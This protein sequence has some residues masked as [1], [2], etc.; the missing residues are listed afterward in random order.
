MKIQYSFDT[1]IP[2]NP[3]RASN[4]DVE[5]GGQAII[6]TLSDK[7]DPNLFIRFQSW[8]ET[9]EHTSMKHF[10]GKRVRVTIECLDPPTQED[11]ELLKKS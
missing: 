2:K 5:D 1:K 8:D 9:K 6:V 3:A 4:I 10:L 11:F 7:H